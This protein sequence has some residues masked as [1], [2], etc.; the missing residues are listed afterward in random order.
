MSDTVLVRFTV[1]GP[2]V[3]KERPR[4][5]RG[6]HF[7]TPTKTKIYE[8]AVR[9]A[10]LCTAKRKLDPPA[11]WVRVHCFFRNGRHPDPDNVLKLVLDGLCGHAYPNDRAVNSSV[12]L[13][14]DADR[15]RI[16]VEVG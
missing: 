6:R 16:E 3:G 12:D 4:K 15:P 7:Y 9:L 10:F 5:G 13:V 14:T 1:E 11:T 2:P 8:Q